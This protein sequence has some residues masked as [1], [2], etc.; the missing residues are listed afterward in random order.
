MALT[1]LKNPYICVN[2]GG[3]LS[4]G[5][6]QM[7]SSSGNFSACGCGVVAGLDLLLYLCRYHEGCRAAFLSECLRDAVIPAESYDKT[8][9]KLS[10]RF[11]PLIPRSGINGI[12]LAIG[13]NAFFLRYSLPYL[14][15]WGVPKKKLFEEIRSLLEKDLPVILSVGPN[16][17]VLWGKSRLTYYGRRPDGSFYPAGNVK[18]HYV[19]V[20]GIDEDYLT[21]SSWGR[22]LY[23]SRSEY[24]DYIRQSSSGIVT[25]ILSLKER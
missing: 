22:K 17:P 6:N 2:Y 1:E 4:Y 16:F 10:L 15:V 25:N 18:S 23:L 19:T 12:S 24:T 5:G 11:L 13:M 3:V 9:K 14:A 21:V 7:G 20:T 8:A